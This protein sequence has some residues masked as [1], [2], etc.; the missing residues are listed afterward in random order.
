MPTTSSYDAP[1]KSVAAVDAFTMLENFPSVAVLFCWITQDFELYAAF[2]PLADKVGIAT[3]VLR[4]GTNVSFITQESY[5]GYMYVADSGNQDMQSS[6][7]MDQGCR[8]Q[9]VRI[10]R[11]HP[12]LV[13]L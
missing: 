13:I 2:H 9:G 12:C 5:F 8:K 10:R 7:P 1:D 6:M 11:K 4:N 3:F